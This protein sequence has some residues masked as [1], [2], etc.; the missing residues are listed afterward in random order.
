RVQFDPPLPQKRAALQR[1]WPAHSPA[2]KT[3]M[4]YS[5][6]FWRDKGLNG[7]IFQVDGPILWAFDNS[8]PGGEIGVINAFISN[9]SVPS[10]HKA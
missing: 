3:A 5:R 1:A 7:H 10:D 6:P 4:V 8:P 9:A 2:R